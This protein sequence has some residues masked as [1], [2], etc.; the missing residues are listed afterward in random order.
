MRGRTANLKTLEFLRDLASQNGGQCLN[1]GRAEELVS[2]PRFECA[3]AHIWQMSQRKLFAGY[4]CPECEN[5]R[6]L[7]ELKAL[8]TAKGGKLLSKRYVGVNEYYDVE[9]SQK[10]RWRVKGGNFKNGTWCRKCAIQNLGKRRRH[11]IEK[12]QEIA[13]NKGGECLSREYKNR[14]TDLTW[15][16]QNGHVWKARPG[17]IVKGGWCRKCFF[18][19]QKDT[20]DDLKQFARTKGGKCLAKRYEDTNQRIEWECGSG[21]KWIARPGQVK[22]GSWCPHC[23]GTAR[24]TIEEMKEMAEERGGQCVSSKYTNSTTKLLWECEKGHKWKSTPNSVK[25]GNWCA[26]CS[27]TKKHTLS[28]MKVLARSRGGRCL[29]SSYQN[30]KVPLLWECDKG[31]TWKTKANT[32]LL[33]R[34]CPHCARNVRLTIEDMKATAKKFGGKCLSRQYI[35]STKKLR[36]ECHEGHQWDAVPHSIRRGHWCPQCARKNYGTKNKLK[37][38]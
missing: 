3:K 28:E 36:W 35:N 25:V 19:S 22:H 26:V 13:R 23:S 7:D 9:C 14:R 1:E 33:G 24:G 29:S 6:K 2:N 16:C 8:A 21:H 4:W 37:A 20:L 12:M 17:N 11:G 10:H 31:H 27:G 32:V 15:R 38:A 30:N 5:E 18:E 34:W